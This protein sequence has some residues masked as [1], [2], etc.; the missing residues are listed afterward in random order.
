MA[1]SRSPHVSSQAGNPTVTEQV[2]ALL[3]LL[4]PI[5]VQLVV[6]IA[7]QA[8][9]AA[10]SVVPFIAVASL[11]RSLV[12]QGLSRPDELWRW[13]TIALT[14]L[15]VRAIATLAAGALTHY[16]DND[17][18]YLLRRRLASRL[19]RAPLGWFT[20]RSAG[21]IKKGVADDVAAMHHLV[22]HAE[23]ELTNAIVVPLATLAY[24][25][26]VNWAL[27]LAVLIPLLLGFYLY[28]R[29]LSAGKG[30]LDQYSTAMEQVSTAGVE[31]MQGISVVKTFGQTGRAYQRFRDRTQSFVD[32]FWGMVMGSRK[33]TTAGDVTLAPITSLVVV[34][35]SGTLLAQLGW[36]DAADV[37]AFAIL[38]LGITG[39]LFGMWFAL[40]ATQQAQAAAIRV[41]QLLQTPVLEE[42]EETTLPAGEVLELRDVGFSYDGAHQ[43]LHRISFQMRPGTTT[44]LVGHSGSGKSTISRLIPRFWDPNQGQ[45]MLGGVD[46]RRI[47]SDEL[48]RHISFV[49]QDVQLLRSSVL[50]NMR[51]ARPDATMHSV[52]EAARSAQIHDRIMELPRGYDSVVGEDAVLSGGEAQRIS[53]ARALLANAP[54]LVLDEATAFADPESE[55]QI[56]DALAELVAG[57]TLLVIAHR[58][59]TI[60]HVDN[61]IVLDHGRLAESGT[62]DSLLRRNGVYA[63][64]W[65][66]HS[67]A[68]LRPN[69]PTEN[70]SAKG[71]FA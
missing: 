21:A 53:I 42:P 8:V 43:A 1:R 52:Y 44:A 56:Q 40:T 66:S 6:A 35:G 23:L 60:E 15:L 16:A 47:S 29:Q 68:D 62:H 13:S 51:I 26:S 50:D 41:Q 9:A 30:Q 34:V 18:Q 25:F 7:I 11:S 10:S 28:S 49:F 37:I 3:G 57:R 65:L 14:A 71:I 2:K 33:T 5:R 46:I 59:S 19:E 20:Q 54:I 4:R 70:T 38:G 24:L 67:R 63:R 61:I 31:F 17:L 36:A 48:F 22:S 12:E 64:M 69:R 58:L 45:I 32:F 55:A 27:T 39:P